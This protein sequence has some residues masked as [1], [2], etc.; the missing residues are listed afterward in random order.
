MFKDVRVAER[1]MVTQAVVMSLVLHDR[2][3]GQIQNPSQRIPDPDRRRR[4]T[5]SPIPNGN[6]VLVQPD[7]DDGTT[8]LLSD[9]KL[10]S[11]YREDQV[12]PAAS[13]ESFLQANDPL[14]ALLI[15]LVLPH[16]LDPVFEEVEV[17]VRSQL[18]RA[19]DVRVQGPE[20]FDRRKRAHLFQVLVVSLRIHQLTGRPFRVP[21]TIW[22]L[23]LVMAVRDGVSDD[24]A[25]RVPVVRH[26]VC[27]RN[28]RLTLLAPP[29]VR[30]QREL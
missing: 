4:V 24:A 19:H 22:V 20:G 6:D 9:H 30:R 26:V 10:F 13:S 5:G 11:Q 8:N 18:V 17:G 14:S 7:G 15:G 27:E 1:G 12:L 3:Q 29:G 21:E 25:I 16:G 28:N 23:Q 2:V